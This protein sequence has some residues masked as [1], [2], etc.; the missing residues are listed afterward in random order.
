ML[1]AMPRKLIRSSTM[2]VVVRK[3]PAGGR[4]GVL[5]LDRILPRRLFKVLLVSVFFFEGTGHTRRRN[6]VRGRMMRVQNQAGSSRK[7][8]SEWGS[9]EVKMSGLMQELDFGGLCWWL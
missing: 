6:G 8:K 9:K 1:G 7:E 3:R 4:V 2:K 5:V